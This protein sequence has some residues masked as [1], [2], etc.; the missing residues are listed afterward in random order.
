LEIKAEIMGY[1]GD[2]VRA[3]FGS[4]KSTIKLLDVP[5]PTALE[6]MHVEKSI[7]HKSGVRALGKLQEI[8][9]PEVVI[10]SVEMSLMPPP[11]RP[12]GR[13]TH[14]LHGP[15]MAE[16]RKR[17]R[18][19]LPERRPK[20]YEALKRSGLMLKEVRERASVGKETIRNALYGKG[21]GPQSAH[22]KAAVLGEG[23][24]ESEV[25]ALEEESF[26]KS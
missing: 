13:I 20:T 10:R 11:E 15:E 8:G 26:R 3:Y 17:T 22:A 4:S 1:P 6:L 5:Q 18:E 16:Q 21:V 23:F 25:R 14:N 24:S 7:L 19:S 9:A 2:Q 12:R